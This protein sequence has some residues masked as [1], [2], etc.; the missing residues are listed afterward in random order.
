MNIVLQYKGQRFLLFAIV[1]NDGSCPAVEFLD[2]LKQNDL[3]SHKSIVNVYLR[4]ANSGPIM[5]IEK[6]RPIKGRDN[7]FEFKSKQGARILYFYLPGKKTVL[8][9]GFYKGAPTEPE[10]DRAENMRDQYIEESKNER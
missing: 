7:L 5:N 2:E 1:C 3:G 10:Y 9:H 4:H 8:T 6:S